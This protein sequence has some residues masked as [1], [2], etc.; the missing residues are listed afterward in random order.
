M[1]LTQLDSDLYVKPVGSAKFDL[2]I[3]LTEQ[4]TE[5][6]SAAGLTGLFEFS[7]DVFKQS[8]IRAIADR[9]KRFL[10]EVAERPHLPIGQVNILSDKER[11]TFSL[12]K[13]TIAQL[14]Q[15]HS[16]PALFE[17]K[18]RSNPLIEWL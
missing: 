9:M 1:K 4:R 7:T 13:K 10:T 16:L 5:T 2:T 3:E 15:A 18:R 6:G 12:T 8:T 14:D 17:K 11:Q